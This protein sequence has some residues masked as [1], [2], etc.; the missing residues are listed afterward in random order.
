MVIETTASLS[1]ETFDDVI[2]GESLFRAAC[3]PE[4]PNNE[5]ESR[6][7]VV[8]GYPFGSDIP[9]TGPSRYPLP[10]IQHEGDLVRGY[11][12]DGDEHQEIAVL[13]LPTFKLDGWVA[14]GLSLT[15]KKFLDG[16]HADGKT[17]L[18]IDMSGNGG[19]DVN[20]GFNIFRILFPHASLETRTR[21]RRTELI[22]LMGKI[23]TST[24]AKARYK[25][26]FPLDLPL[27]AHLAVS[28]DQRDAF[29]SWEDLYGSTGMVSEM[30]ATFN[31][32]SASTEDNPI[33]GY[34]PV[35]KSHASPI[36]SADRIVIVSHVRRVQKMKH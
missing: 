10:L 4:S 9:P 7:R 13:Q 33:E 22:R 5:D 25:D 11:Y 1:M 2:D 21:F 18:I 24:Q 31:F 17:N 8:R 35:P 20:V 34:G 30:Y 12:L 14:K 19:G 16:A 26:G 28:P 15:A 32:T 29:E 23:F 27:A 36:F 6:V 3:L